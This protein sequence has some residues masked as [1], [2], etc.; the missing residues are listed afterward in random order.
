MSPILLLLVNVL[1]LVE[2]RRFVGPLYWMSGAG[3]VVLKGSSAI[4]L[5][6]APYTSCRVGDLLLLRLWRAVIVVPVV[7]MLGVKISFG[8][9][10]CG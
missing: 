3:V 1:S 2:W 7:G 4:L 10:S 5:L 6:G 9:L 8:W